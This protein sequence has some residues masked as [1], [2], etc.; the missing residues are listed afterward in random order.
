MD[1]YR[2]VAK[3]KNTNKETPED[4]I[5][6]TATGRTA[7]YVTYAGKLFNEKSLNKCTIKA[8]GTAL[9]TAVT[10][11]EII[12]RRFKGLHQITK[13]G[14]TEIVDEYEP[15]EEGLDKVTD[16]RQVSFVEISL[17]KEPLDTK[18]KGYQPP[19]S[20]DL[21]KEF[22]PEEMAR[23]RGGRGG[24]RNGSRNK[25]SK[26]KSK[27][28]K[29]SKGSKGKES[30]SKGKSSKSKGKGADRSASRGKSGKD[31]GNKGGKSSGKKGDSGKKGKGKSSN[32]AY[33]S[34]GGGYDSYGY[35]SYGNK[36][37]GY[38]SGGYDDGYAALSRS[39]KGKGK[40]SF[41]KSMDKGKGKSKGKKY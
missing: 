29:G 34:Y 5:R 41:G 23:G 27:G 1:K 32:N 9:A 7:T 8:T 35:S 17:S 37:Y 6:V 36:G 40:G 4:E 26:G 30:Q 24:R 33:D 21:V 20:E 16:V 31:S 38:G 14:S 3:E 39:V 10:V 25:G 22:S 12:K 18:D 19:I 2:R 11:V 13:L 15:L 28:R